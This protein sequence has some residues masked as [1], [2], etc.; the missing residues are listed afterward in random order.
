MLSGIW[1]WDWLAASSPELIVDG[2]VALLVAL[3]EASTHLQG[4][5]LR[6]KVFCR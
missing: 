6:H 2:E 4:F 3:V 5:A 1:P